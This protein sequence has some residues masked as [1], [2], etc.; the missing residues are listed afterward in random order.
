MRLIEG[1][2]DPGNFILDKIRFT[3]GPNSILVLAQ[4][5]VQANINDTMENTDNGM[6]VR[7]AMD[8]R[9]VAR[10]PDLHDVGNARGFSIRMAQGD[11]Q[12]GL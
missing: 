6:G 9:I 10:G 1:G 8:G 7:M 12:I 5:G 11:S 2:A 4:K 3:E